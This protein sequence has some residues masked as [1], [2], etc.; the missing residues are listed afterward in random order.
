MAIYSIRLTFLGLGLAETM[1]A[2]DEQ[3]DELQKDETALKTLL[4]EMMHMCLWGNATVRR[5]SISHPFAHH[6][7][8]ADEHGYSGSLLADKHYSR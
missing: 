4:G 6:R 2:L 8:H 3:K 1:I 5:Q 7:P